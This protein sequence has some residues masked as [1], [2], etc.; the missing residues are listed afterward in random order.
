LRNLKL[1]IAYDGSNYQGWQIQPQAETI[2]GV[3][4]EKL[5]LITGETPR[6]HAAGRTDAGVHALGQVVNFSLKHHIPASSLLLALNST[7]PKDIVINDI[8]EVAPDFQAR[9]C[10][11]S[12]K[13]VYR[14][15]QQPQPSP[16]E[17]HYAWHIRKFLDIESMRC[18]AR[19]LIGSHN[20]ASFQG[21]GCTAKN[22]VKTINEIDFQQNSHILSIV[23]SG[24]GFLRH[25]VRNIV[26][27]LIEV[28][29]G[30]LPPDEIKVILEACD[31]RAAG[32]TA[33][34]RGLYLAK[35]EY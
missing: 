1:I 33:P 31:R 18:S 35:V 28:G 8:Q 25:M 17:R 13:Y 26:G 12:K 11:R 7:L 27:T 10:A 34:P 14:I 30:K 2:Q 29:R 23:I 6:L 24:D 9:Y 22:L 5:K 32:P 15:L 20:F 19:Y 3:L 16:F 21:A 4:E